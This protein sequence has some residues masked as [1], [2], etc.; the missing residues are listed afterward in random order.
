MNFYQSTSYGK[1]ESY[2]RSLSCALLTL[3]FTSGLQAQSPGFSFLLN[4]LDP[5]PGDTAT[6]EVSLSSAWTPGGRDDTLDIVYAYSGM[7]FDP[8]SKFQITGESG[9][10]DVQEY[11]ATFS[12]DQAAHELHLRLVFP[13]AYSVADTGYLLSISNL[14]SV[15][16]EYELRQARP[17]LSQPSSLLL[18]WERGKL[19]VHGAGEESLEE[20]DIYSLSGQRLSHWKGTVTDWRI[21]TEGWGESILLIRIRTN[22][23]IQFHK[24]G[25]Q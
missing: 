21:G 20:I 12:L 23:G 13:N 16:D 10:L 9:W 1:G 5:E 4:P 19:Y 3:L 15:I 18:Q 7:Q 22:Q 14:V 17:G 6:L 25:K 8:G 24:L 11:S 2:V